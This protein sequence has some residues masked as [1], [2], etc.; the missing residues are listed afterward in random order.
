MTENKSLAQKMPGNLPELR[1][2]PTS[3]QSAPASK[4]QLK[5]TATP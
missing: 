2:L 1:L 5:S 3:P 4:A